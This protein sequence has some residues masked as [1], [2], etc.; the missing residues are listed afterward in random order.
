M[1]S[2]KLEDG[3][4]F[5]TNARIFLDERLKRR[6]MIDSMNPGAPGHNFRNTDFLKFEKLA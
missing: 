3:S 6:E 2:W 4:F 1:L 5:V